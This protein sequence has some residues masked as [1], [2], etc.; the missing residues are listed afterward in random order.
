MVTAHGTTSRA[1]QLR[2]KTR[3]KSS[4]QSTRQTSMVSDS[5]DYKSKSTRYST[6]RRTTARR[7]L[8]ERFEDDIPENELDPREKKFFGAREIFRRVPSNDPFCLRHL[9]TCGVCAVSGNDQVK[10]LLVFCQG[11]TFTYHQV[12]LGPRAT[13][14]HLVTKIADEN[15]IL[16]CRHCLGVAHSKDQLCP[17]EGNCNVCKEK[18]SMSKPLRER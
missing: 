5:D 18:G 8:H 14:D 11:C 13:R 4:H 2:R 10:G 1:R 17:H 7:N 3:Q 6:R 9:N 16:Q 15:F 12:C